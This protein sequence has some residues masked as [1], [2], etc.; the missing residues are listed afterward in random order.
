MLNRII[1]NIKELYLE[2][3]ENLSGFIVVTIVFSVVIGWMLLYIDSIRGIMV[4]TIL[5]IGLVAVFMNPFIGV[6]GVVWAFY[7]LAGTAW[8][9]SEI[10]WL[11]PE[12]MIIIVTTVCWCLKIIVSRNMCF[13]SPVQLW[14]LIALL[15]C[16]CVSS[17]GAVYSSA[18]SWPWNLEFLKLI[19]IFFVFINLIN[20]PA[21]LNIVYW[22]IVLPCAYLALQGCRSYILEGYSRLENIGECQLKGSNELAS[23]LSLTIPFLFYKFFSKEKLERM[24]GFLVFPIIFCITISSS[25]GAMLEASLMI[26]LLICYTKLSPKI[27]ALMA[28]LI[29]AV[30][31]FSPPESWERM[32][33]TKDYK[34]E[35]SAVSRIGLAKAGLRMW[36][37]YPIFG[38]GQDNFRHI[39]LQY[40]YEG[41][42]GRQRVAHN[43]YIQIL[44]EGGIVCFLIY[45]LFLFLLFRDLRFVKKHAL[46]ESEGFQIKH[47]ANALEITLYG[48]LIECLFSNRI[49]YVMPMFFYA[50]CTALKNIVI[51]RGLLKEE[52]RGYG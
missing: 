16:M 33:T 27:I 45:I 6:A 31:I 40:Y 22:M 15:V 19:I 10:S 23:A 24:L 28:V 12:F 25:R 51:F 35:G 30:I 1:E 50:L 21:R 2:C 8:Y 47:M 9:M 20:S 13:F 39:V 37:D 7:F 5:M 49:Y 4:I 3:K 32:K 34:T 38:V 29:F 26:I 44:S 36:K 14:V 43:T 42:G 11:K 18:I 52:G 46:V 41:E 48:F 17:L